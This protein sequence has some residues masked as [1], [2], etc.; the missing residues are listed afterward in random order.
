MSNKASKSPTGEDREQKDPHFR[1][2]EEQGKQA[3]AQ[4][5]KSGS[6]AT[7]KHETNSNRGYDEDQPN[8]PIRSTGSL[9]KNQQNLPTGEPD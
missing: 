1:D 7:P 2:E 5:P 8:N 9:D 4:R 6:A 3:Q